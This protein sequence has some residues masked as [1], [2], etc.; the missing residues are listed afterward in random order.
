MVPSLPQKHKKH[1]AA[2]F[3]YRNDGLLDT[4]A[5][6]GTAAIAAVAYDSAKRPTQLAI[7]GSGVAAA[8]GPS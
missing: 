5:W 6:S 8:G 4:R 3:T 1:K 2:S 7:T